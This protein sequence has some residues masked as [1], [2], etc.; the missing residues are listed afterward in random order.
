[1]IPHHHRIE[2][3]LAY[4]EGNY[5]TA[6]RELETAIQMMEKTPRVPYRDGAIAIARA[7]LCCTLAK[8]NDRSGSEKNYRAAQSYLEATEETKLIEECKMELGKK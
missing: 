8:L 2:G 4:V 6:K 1:M 7:Y 3:L 5:E